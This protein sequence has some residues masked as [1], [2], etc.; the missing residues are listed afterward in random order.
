MKGG[1]TAAIVAALL[2][3]PG[4]GLSGA[5]RKRP[6]QNHH[7]YEYSGNRLGLRPDPLATSVAEDL[8]ACLASTDYDTE[9][10]CID[11]VARSRGLTGQEVYNFYMEVQVWNLKMRGGGEKKE[12]PQVP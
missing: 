6:Y 1:F 5:E 2:C 7:T 10:R 3:G 11:Q 9:L 8:A 4:P 12:G